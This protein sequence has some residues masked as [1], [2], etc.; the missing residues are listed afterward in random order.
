MKQKEY[1][2]VRRLK[3]FVRDSGGLNIDISTLSYNQK[4]DI[5]SRT[6]IIIVEGS[7][8]SNALMMLRQQ[9]TGN[10]TKC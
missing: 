7:G 2:T 1:L 10:N 8:V 3:D 5:L 4:I 6:N 9:D